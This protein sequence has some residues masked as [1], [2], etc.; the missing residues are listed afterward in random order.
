MR[1]VLLIV[2]LIISLWPS[3]LKTA[4]SQTLRL[5]FEPS[6]RVC[7]CLGLLS[8]FLLSQL[9]TIILKKIY[10]AHLQF[11][12]CSTILWAAETI[13]TGDAPHDY[14]LCG[15]ERYLLFTIF[16]LDIVIF[17]RLFRVQTPIDFIY[18]HQFRTVS[19]PL[20]SK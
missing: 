10:F 3:A 15:P 20:S 14:S 13:E 4:K 18:S 17:V 2:E 16:F 6:F 7:N 8:S 12:I 11:L 9:M 1:I 19:L 5:S